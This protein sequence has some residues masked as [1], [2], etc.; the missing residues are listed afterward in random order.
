ML[1]AIR[2]D[3]GIWGH[4]RSLYNV[5]NIGITSGYIIIVFM[6]GVGLLFFNS[7]SPLGW[8]IAAGAIVALIFGVIANAHFSLAYLSAFDLLVIVTLLCGGLGLL[9]S[10]MIRRNN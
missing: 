9:L 5:G 4:G 6:L 8:L 1:Q 2:V 3:I 7:K 10:A